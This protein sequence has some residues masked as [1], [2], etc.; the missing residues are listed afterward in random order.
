MAKKALFISV[1]D[2]KKKSII[3]GNVD[4]DKILQFVE[5][6]Q[7]THVQNYLG[8]TLYKKLQ[9]LIVAGTISDVG[10]E[11]YST[12][13]VDYIKP[14]LIWYSQA[15]YLPFSLFQLKNGGLYKHQSENSD[16]VSKGE[17]D[18]IIQRTRDNAEFY[19]KRFLDY[20]CENSSLYPEYIN[21]DTGEMYPDKDV[22]YSGGWVI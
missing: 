19:T 17:L 2:L 1:D 11:D 22:N 21:N 6:A 4:S 18:Y 8:G 14:M 9:S 3:D 13:L 5:V 7:D 15:T 16:A 12:L 10:N 20:M